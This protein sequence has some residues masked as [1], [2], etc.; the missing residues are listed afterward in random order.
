M[1]VV[2]LPVRL[3]Q[4]RAEIIT[5][6]DDRAKYP[7]FRKKFEN[8]SFRYPD[9]AQLKIEKD[10]IFLPKA[11][12]VEMVMHREIVGTVSNVTVSRQGTYW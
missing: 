3:D 1:D 8:E 5:N 12:W 6:L 10:R 9:P 11:G 2:V 7:K 4:H